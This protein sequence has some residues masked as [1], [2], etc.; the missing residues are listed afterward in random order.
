[1][2]GQ[3][4]EVAT[5]WAPIEVQQSFKPLLCPVRPTLQAGETPNPSA[6]ARGKVTNC[7]LGGWRW[8]RGGL[9]QW[10]ALLKAWLRDHTW[11]ISRL[12]GHSHAEGIWW[13]LDQATHRDHC[14]PAFHWRFN[15]NIHIYRLKNT[16]VQKHRAINSETSADLCWRNCHL[17]L[18]SWWTL[19]TGKLLRHINFNM[20]CLLFS[21]CW[22]I[23]QAPAAHPERAAGREWPRAASTDCSDLCFS[24][25]PIANPK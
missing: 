23:P 4:G 12:V 21:E 8:T 6:E 3:K 10:D 20:G 9:W 5:H 14:Q 11:K 17:N 25:C 7:T 22:D 19:I 16:G 24:S 18:A 13:Q 2:K 15:D 1:M